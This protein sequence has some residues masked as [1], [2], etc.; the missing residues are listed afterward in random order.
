MTMQVDS[1]QAAAMAQDEGFKEGI[2]KG[3]AE[4]AGV[5]E[6]W[7]EVTIEVNNR[8]L[9][10]AGNER[11]LQTATLTVS[12]TITIPAGSNVNVE[13]IKENFDNTQTTQ[14]TQAVQNKL[15]E[16]GLD[17]TVDILT[18]GEPVVTFVPVT[19]PSPAPAPTDESSARGLNAL[20]ALSGGAYALMIAIF[21]PVLLAL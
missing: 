8:R 20:K 1:S 11:R 16:A 7:I 3:V 21:A 19:S 12:Y 9:N 15:V 4:H 5:S 14:L 10:G 17:I 13:A 2:A 6:D 18:I